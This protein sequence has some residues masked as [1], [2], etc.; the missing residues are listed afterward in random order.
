[1]PQARVETAQVTM[2]SSEAPATKVDALQAF[3]PLVGTV[4]GETGAV[5]DH[6]TAMVAGREAGAVLPPQYTITVDSKTVVQAFTTH[7]E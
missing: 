4:V 2:V 5:Y 6:V 7:G 1:M 3:M